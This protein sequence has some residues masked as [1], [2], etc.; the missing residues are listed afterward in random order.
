MQPI[1]LPL[2]SIKSWHLKQIA[3]LFND[4]LYDEVSRFSYNQSYIMVLDIVETK[5][6]KEPKETIEKS[7]PKNRCN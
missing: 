7:F 2:V 5:L 4:F 3:D 1:T 6:F